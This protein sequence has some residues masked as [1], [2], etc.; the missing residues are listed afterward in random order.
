MHRTRYSTEDVHCTRKGNTPKKVPHQGKQCAQEGVAPSKVSHRK[1]Y[2]TDKGIP[3]AKTIHRGKCSWGRRS[4]TKGLVV[5]TCQIRINGRWHKL[6]WHLPPVSAG[7]KNA[8]PGIIRRMWCG[9]KGGYIAF[10]TPLQ[11]ETRFF[12]RKIA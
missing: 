11:P 6:R 8:K 1:R 7:L 3:P 9:G 12:F 5:T 4:G 2:F 10:L